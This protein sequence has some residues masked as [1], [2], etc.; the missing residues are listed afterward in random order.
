[1]IALVFV[2]TLCVYATLFHIAITGTRDG[3]G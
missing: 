2:Y 3:K 1:M